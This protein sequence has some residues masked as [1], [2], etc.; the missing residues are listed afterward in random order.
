MNNEKKYSVVTASNIPGEKSEKFVSQTIEKLLDG[1]IPYS[2][3]SEYTIVLLATPINDVEEKNEA[4]R[5][6]FWSCTIFIVADRL[7]FYG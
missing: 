7:S 1:I 3:K 6:L 2:K 4:W 5:V